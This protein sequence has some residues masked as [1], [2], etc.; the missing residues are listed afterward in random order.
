MAVTFDDPAAVERALAE[1]F[2]TL[3]VAP[4]EFVDMGFGSLVVETGDGVIFRIAR[5]ARTAAGHAREV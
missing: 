5:H 4:L 3:A 1:A 2:P